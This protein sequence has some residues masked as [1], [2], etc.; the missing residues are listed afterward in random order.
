MRGRRRGLRSRGRLVCAVL[1]GAAVSLCTVA[2]TGGAAARSTVADVD[3]TVATSPHRVFPVEST[4]RV[5]SELVMRYHL[6]E[7]ASQGPHVWYRLRLDLLVR[8][9]TAIPS[10]A[11]TYISAATAGWTCAQFKLSTYE[12][13]SRR[14]VTWSSFDLV[15]G[16]R[17]GAADGTTV[18]L[19]MDNYLQNKGVR[20]GQS[21]LTLRLEELQGRLLREVEVLGTT[22]ILQTTDSPYPLKVTLRSLRSVVRVG[23]EFTVKVALSTENRRR[24]R[25]VELE[26]LSDPQRLEVIAVYPEKL[27]SVD[28]RASGTVVLR[29]LETGRQ[30]L[31]LVA[32]TPTQR[33]SAQLVVL[34]LPSETTWSRMLSL[35]SNTKT[36]V[37]LLTVA[38][39]ALLAA[40]LRGRARRQ[41]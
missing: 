26:A 30:S 38:F 39:G 1:A 20:P 5:H 3:E 14:G 8:L 17:D 37:A 7:G 4:R 40:V 41:R 33:P 18:R 22:A 10:R 2:P 36:Q 24:V 23:D 21:D 16:A 15:R 34:V 6:P 11:L 25:Q 19:S 12:S 9:R 13:G 32:D 28:G 27:A 29:A 35:L 31:L